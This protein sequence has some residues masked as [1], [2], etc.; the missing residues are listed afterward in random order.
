MNQTV[1]SP[2]RSAV[3]RLAC[4]GRLPGLL[5]AAVVWQLTGCADAPEIAPT[6]VEAVVVSAAAVPEVA[7]AE[8][9]YGISVVGLQL[10]AAGTMLD[11]RYRVLDAIKAAPLLDRKQRP[12]LLDPVR[13]GARLGVP[14]TPVLGQIRQTA[15]NNVVYTDRNYFI[16]F[17]N[18]GRAVQRGDTVSLMLGQAKIADLTVR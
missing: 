16:M 8:S 4:P 17:G 1:P 2:T 11:F 12:Y 15:R 9:A 7:S 13:G 14:D 10:S 3:V 18:P 5:L 6:T